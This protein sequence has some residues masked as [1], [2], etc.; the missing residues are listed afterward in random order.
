MRNA[1]LTC[2]ASTIS[3]YSLSC[4]MHAHI[5]VARSRQ[6]SLHRSCSNCGCNFL[7]DKHSIREKHRNPHAC[8]LLVL[9]L[10]IVITH[11]FGGWGV[12]F[13]V[14]ACRSSIMSTAA[15][16]GQ[17]KFKWTCISI[18]QAGGTGSHGRRAGGSVQA[19]GDSMRLS[20]IALSSLQIM[21]HTAAVAW[22]QGQQQHE[23]RAAGCGQYL[24]LRRWSVAPKQSR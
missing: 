15:P 7:F 14:L 19:S 18:T 1:G 6:C 8:R 12:S 16:I 9:D 2:R 24:L 4:I 5:T 13:Q 23:V 17:L 3:V 20:R 22:L 11:R 10:M 21:S